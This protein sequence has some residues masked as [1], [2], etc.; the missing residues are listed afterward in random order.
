MNI[1]H[2]VTPNIQVSLAW[3]KVRVFRLS[4]AHL[5]ETGVKQKVSQRTLAPAAAPVDPKCSCTSMLLPREPWL[6]VGTGGTV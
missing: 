5:A 3:E 4:G 6:T 2:S 1:S